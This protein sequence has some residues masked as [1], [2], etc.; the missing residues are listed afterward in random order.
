MK[1]QATVMVQYAFE[2][3]ADNEDEAEQFAYDNYHNYAY[4]A[5]VYSIRLDEEDEDE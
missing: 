3:E 2:V 5:D 1:Y 4:F